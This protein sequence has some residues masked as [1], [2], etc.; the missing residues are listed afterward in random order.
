MKIILSLLLILSTL[1]PLAACSDRITDAPAQPIAETKEKEAEVQKPA[2]VLSVPTPMTW[3]DIKAIPVATADM[4]SDQLRKI[5]VDYFRLQASFQWTPNKKF[6]YIIRS[7]NSER[8]FLPG[9]V[10]GGIPYVTS[11]K[12]GGNLYLW[13]EYYD[14]ETGVLDL[15]KMSGQDL[16][17]LLGNHCAHGAFWGWT[18]VV[19]SAEIRGTKTLSHK[20]GCLA[21]GPYKYDPEL[22]EYSTTDPA[23][24][25]DK[26]CLE[27]GEQIMFQSY[28]QLL[29]ADGIN[30]THTGNWHVRMISQAATVVYNPDGTINGD[31]SYVL[32]IEQASSPK[33][34]TCPD[35]TVANIMSCV[36]KKYTFASL[37]KSRYIPFTFAEFHGLDPVEKGEVGI[38]LT[39]TAVTCEQLQAATV[40]SNY[41]ISNVTVQAV[42]E[43]GEVLYR[44][45]KKFTPSDTGGNA[46]ICT[47][48]SLEKAIIPATLNRYANKDDVKIRILCRIST[49][50]ELVA[51][52]GSLTK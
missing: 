31:E 12:G 51:Y 14:E 27:N 26:V 21:V 45:V 13:M 18:R 35:G 23:L 38:D 11:S 32:C 30:A 5:C 50:E 34:Y 4:S 29:P 2:K 43:S 47:G 24:G 3:K 41:S 48:L 28:A 37:Y 16:M 49:G 20:N 10:Y 15:T 36:D 46:I 52:E 1:L 17:D 40:T 8:K 33:D 44:Y 6:S 19:N 9:T 42:N 22:E 25:T 7:G 39:E